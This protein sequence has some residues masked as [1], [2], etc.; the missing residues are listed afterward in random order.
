MIT[1]IIKNMLSF[2]SA[3][4]I[5]FLVDAYAPHIEGYYF[6]VV[7]NTRIENVVQIDDFVV[8][9]NGEADKL[10]DCKFEK[11]EW[12]YTSGYNSVLV[13]IQTSD[14]TLTISPGIFLF[15]PWKIKLT[16]EQLRKNSYAIVYHSCHPGWLTET[17]FYP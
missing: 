12:Y 8:A 15:G 1:Y 2:V 7:G 3:L 10:R 9:F 16:E 5:L 17:K 4:S 11:I 13:P 14:Q 6:P